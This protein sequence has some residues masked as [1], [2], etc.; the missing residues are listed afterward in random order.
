MSESASPTYLPT[1]L[2]IYLPTYLP[3]YL[4]SKHPTKLFCHGL[5]SSGAQK[6]SLKAT[7]LYYERKLFHNTVIRR[8]NVDNS[9]MWFPVVKNLLVHCDFHPIT[10]STSNAIESTFNTC[11]PLH[12]WNFAKNILIKITNC[13]A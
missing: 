12:H 8:A 4:V 7:F 3:T 2:S 9:Q 11:N 13:I 10:C 1:Y 6:P 5:S